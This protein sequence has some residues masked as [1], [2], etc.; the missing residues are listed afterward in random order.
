MWIAADVKLNIISR[1]EWNALPVNDTLDDLVMPIK[2]IIILHTVTK[3]C[4]TKV[5]IL[6]LKITSNLNY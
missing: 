5:C 2:R 1:N 4:L 3:E 6:F